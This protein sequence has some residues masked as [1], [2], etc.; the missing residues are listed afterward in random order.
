MGYVPPKPEDLPEEERWQLDPNKFRPENEEFYGPTGTPD[1]V[2]EDNAIPI[3]DNQKPTNDANEAIR[4]VM[5]EGSRNYQYWAQFDNYEI[6]MRDGSTAKFHRV[7][8]PEMEFDELED[9]RTQIEC[10]M[11]MKE[12]PLNAVQIRNLEKLF[13]RKLG[14]YYLVNSKTGKPMTEKE[15]LQAKDHHQIAGILKSNL[16]RSNNDASTGPQG[17]K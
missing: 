17:K 10:R 7:E 14:Q 8:I 2:K 6:E 12:K 16:L 3:V 9:I 5:M 1:D 13:L 4:R 15:R 11:D